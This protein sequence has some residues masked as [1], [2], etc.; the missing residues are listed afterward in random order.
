MFSG[1]TFALL[2]QCAF[3]IDNFALLMKGYIK[4]VIVLADSINLVLL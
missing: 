4:M 3:G 1:D 2:Y